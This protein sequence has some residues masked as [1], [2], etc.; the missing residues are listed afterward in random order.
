MP[1]RYPSRPVHGTDGSSTDKV[2]G[3]ILAIARDVLSAPSL[4]SDDDLADHGATSLALTRIIAEVH[5]T[6]GLDIDAR[7]LSDRITVGAL[8]QVG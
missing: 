1:D 3:E 6:L 4:E 2:I 8:A 5:L 7:D